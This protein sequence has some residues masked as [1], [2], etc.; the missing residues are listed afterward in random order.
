MAVLPKMRLHNNLKQSTLICAPNAHV[1][2]SA[3][4]S[5]PDAIKAVRSY[6]QSGKHITVL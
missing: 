5:V 2:E 4:W 6:E 1:A 3:T